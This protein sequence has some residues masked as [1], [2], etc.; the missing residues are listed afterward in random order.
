MR[1]KLN[2]KIKGNYIAYIAYMYMTLAGS[3]L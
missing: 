3:F 2:L 1:D